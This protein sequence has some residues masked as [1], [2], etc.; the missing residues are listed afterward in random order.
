[1]ASGSEWLSYAPLEIALKAT[2]FALITIAVLI[3]LIWGRRTYRGRYFARRDARACEIRQ[4]WSRIISLEIPPATWRNKRLDR[5]LIESILLDQIDLAI[6]SELP[7]L[8]QCLRDSGLLDHYIYE[9]RTWRG[10]KRQRALA[11][12]GRTRTPE[13]IPTLASALD[14][15]SGAAVTA[16]VRALGNVGTPQAMIPILDR[17]AE[18]TLA[19][20]PIR[21]KHALVNGC[22]SEPALLVRYLNEVKPEIR[23]LLA[24]SL[25]QI[26][27]PELAEDLAVLAGDTSPE[28]R[29]SVARALVAC[30]RQFAIGLLFTLILDEVWFVRLRAVA[31]L[32]ELRDAGSIES[33]V[34]CLC[35]NNR[36][37][38]QRA[39]MALVYFEDEGPEILEQVID[40]NDRYALHSLVSELQRAGRYADLLKRLGHGLGESLNQQLIRAAETARREIQQPEAE[41]VL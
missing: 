1:M 16:A 36:I 30:N 33:L 8:V 21:L 10:W 17:L 9:A 5:E 20:P 2:I 38:R 32:G 12:L 37:V 40:T 39:A 19:A 22:Q 29:A 18:G 11:T 31:A 13:A 34:R 24:Q 15:K 35:D 6:P 41:P 26:V 25:G 7:A 4:S 23:D 27:S 14:S 28:V 3:L